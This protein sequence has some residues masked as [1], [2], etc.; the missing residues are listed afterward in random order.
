MSIESIKA[1]IR[2]C[3]GIAAGAYGIQDLAVPAPV[4][5]QAWRIVYWKYLP[6]E[7]PWESHDFYTVYGIREEHFLLLDR[8]IRRNIH[9][10]RTN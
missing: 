4:L 7:N 5:C 9:A 10:K 1:N 2:L 6:R 8:V 3:K